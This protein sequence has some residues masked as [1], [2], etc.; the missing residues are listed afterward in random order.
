MHRQ[1]EAPLWGRDYE[2]PVDFDFLHGPP[3]M[4]DPMI[5]GH[6]DEPITDAERKAGMRYAATPAYRGGYLGLP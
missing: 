3:K 1:G 2:A 5:T 6:R 4:G